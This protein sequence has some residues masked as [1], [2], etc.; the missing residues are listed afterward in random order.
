MNFAPVAPIRIYE[1]MLEEDNFDIIG[2]Y[3]LLLAHDV[4]DNASRY[5]E[6]FR[7]ER[8]KNATIIMDNSVIEL[9]SS[10]SAKVLQEAADIVQATCLA[11]PDVLQDGVKTL[12]SAEAFLKEFDALDGYKPE[13]MFIPQG[14]NTEDYVK[15]AIDM[16]ENFRERIGWWG[17][18]R[19]TT[20]RIVHTRRLLAP[21]LQGLK[22]EAQI[23]LLG[24]SDDVADDLLTC[25][26]LKR[27]VS[28]IDSAVPLRTT[29][30]SVQAFNNAGPRGIWWDTAEYS[31]LMQQNILE[32][33]KLVAGV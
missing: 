20:N 9:G 31:S 30:A 23:H 3:H 22:P 26:E 21:F 2:N 7:D 28:G 25:H 33:R 4:I 32:T 6:V 15:C 8:L 27:I 5:S 29:E 1:D 19:N 11:V 17:V 12:E 24:F 16:S 13:L 18:A 14:F 10:V